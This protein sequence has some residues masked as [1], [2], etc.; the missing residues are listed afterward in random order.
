M[1]RDYNESGTATVTMPPYVLGHGRLLT[2]LEEHPIPVQ[3]AHRSV[4]SSTVVEGQAGGGGVER[5]HIAFGHVPRIEQLAIGRIHHPHRSIIVGGEVGFAVAFSAKIGHGGDE[6]GGGI[7]GVAIPVDIMA[8]AI[9]PGWKKTRRLS[10]G[11]TPA[12]AER[13]PTVISWSFG[14]LGSITIVSPRITCP[15]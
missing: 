4:I 8:G 15:A 13:P 9:A 6:G 2:L 7:A 3:R 5:Q 10:L 14:A 1:D 12:M 11:K